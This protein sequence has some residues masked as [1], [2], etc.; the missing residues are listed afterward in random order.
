MTPYEQCAARATLWG[1][2]ALNPDTRDTT[3]QFHIGINIPGVRGLAPGP[4]NRANR[5]VSRS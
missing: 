5:S 3:L 1:R 2:H 4:H